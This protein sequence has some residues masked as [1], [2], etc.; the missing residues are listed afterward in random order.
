MKK[1]GIIFGAFVVLIL[2][3][4]VI[5]PL[6][7]DVDKYRPEIVNAA[8]QNLNGQLELGHLKLSLF[9][10]IRVEVDGLS[11]KDAQGHDVVSVKDASFF[12]PFF[13][14]LSGSPVVDLQLDSP[15]VN[16]VKNRAGKLNLMS[17][18]KSAQN[19]SAAAQPNTTAPS[20][21]KPATSSQPT[22]NAQAKPEAAQPQTAA[23]AQAPTATSAPVEIPA[24]AAR[25]RVGF[26]LM[27]ALVTY[28][29]ETSGLVTDLKDLNI[30]VK[31][32]SLSRPSQVSVW[33][34]FDTHMVK[35]GKKTLD[36]AGPGR[37]DLVF[38]PEVSGGKLS[39]FT[40]S[41]K[42]DFD[43]LDISIPGTFEKKKGVAANVELAASGSD[44]EMNIE[45]A[46]VNFFNAQVK[47]SGQITNLPLA[48]TV[49]CRVKSNDIEL[50]SW[51]ELIPM[52]REYEL[53]GK[54]SLSAELGG[55]AD[56]LTYQAKL[57]V[58]GLTA[59]AGKL[60]N[61]PRIDGQITLATD[62]IESMLITMH[63][64]GNELKI[65]GK[66]VSF[67][68]PQI[69]IDVTSPGMDLDQLID[70]QAP[71]AK[72]VEA[73]QLIRSA[74]AETE[75]APPDMDA[76]LELIRENK[77]LAATTAN[78]NFNFK[79]FKAK[80]IRMTDMIGKLY[81]KDLAAGLDNF[82]MKMFN[83]TIKAT[84]S[85]QL[86]PKAPTYKFSANVNGLDLQEAIKSQ[87]KMFQNTMTGKANFD[88]AGE[89]AS[90]NPDPAKAN[91]KAKGSMKVAN[92]EF[93]TLD[94]GKMV[95]DGVASALSGV[96]SKIPGLA[97]KIKVPDR[98][99]RYEMISADFGIQGGK[100]SAPNF[101]GKAI[102]NEGI[103][104]K[105]TVQVGLKDQ[106]LDA[107]FQI[108]DTYNWT[109]ARD[110]SAPNL[111]GGEPVQHVLAENNKPFVLPVSAG[112]TMSKPCY[113]YGDSA[114]FIGKIVAN[115]MAGGSKEAAKQKGLDILKKSLG[116]GGGGGKVPDIGGALKGLFGH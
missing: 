39:R 78:V 116:G 104:L 2:A 65:T 66:M 93:A 106:S 21:A 90:F 20:P 81:F 85:S 61:Q 42:A 92:A 58:D 101:V 31:D 45:K 3:A 99:S 40:L 86:R 14:L 49:R 29:D 23:K 91:L 15:S 97:N 108:I 69:A 10:H 109:H 71:A 105:G 112:C 44:K 38:S 89:G 75:K 32:L 35:D 47:T 22:A 79:M 67:K 70:F 8:N 7:V 63:A 17:L 102:P 34:D 48:P 95:V 107:K 82:N 30:V 46:D 16:V 6:V 74:F 76:M 77:M 110:V 94:V 43:G 56:K 114:A 13:P 9:G 12:L 64:P 87:M 55:P 59:K 1:I 24:I 60:K 50:K 36:V 18:M 41:G 51:S 4:I 72:T 5:I 11:L 54:M 26:A 33:S 103:D 83:G 62:Q 111:L 37:I 98:K 52:L 115:N 96:S 57:V 28:K 19:E 113:S 68:A 80:D 100:F 53:G 84:V 25:A 73:I 27:H 88:I